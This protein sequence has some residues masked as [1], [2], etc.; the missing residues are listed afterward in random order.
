[1][2]T[3]L[4]DLN[5]SGR[6]DLM[7]KQLELEAEMLNRGKRRY[8]KKQQQS[9]DSGNES[10]TTH[11]KSLLKRSFD[12][13]IT[14]MI[15]EFGFERKGPKLRAHKL[16]MGMDA[17]AVAVI[18]IKR[19][20]D[21]ISIT[22]KRTSAC[23]KLGG[24]LEDEAY[25]KAYEDHN[26]ALFDIVNK[27][28][29]KRTSH[30][31]YRRNKQL[32][33]SKKDNFKWSSWTEQDKLHVGST[34]LKIF[35][36]ATG[37]CFEQKIRKKH[38]DVYYISPT[39]K[40]MDWIKDVHGLNEYLDPEFLPTII[41]P[42]R[43]KEGMS[44]GGGYY[45]KLRNPI[46]LVSG[47]NVSAHRN[48]LE[49]LSNADM[50][51]IIEGINKVQDTMYKINTSVLQVAD[52]IFDHDEFNVG[53]TIITSKCLDLPNKP[54]DI[55]T[56]LESRKKWKAQATITHA[57]NTKRRSKR[58]TTAKIIQIAK[59]FE[60]EEQIGFPCNLDFRSRMYY[61]PPYLNPQ[62]TD[63]AKSLL[64]FAEK[65]PIGESGFRWLC[66]HLANTYGGDKISL[67]DRV[68]WVTDHKKEILECSQNPHVNHFWQHAD[69]PWQFL[70][71]CM[72]FDKVN[73]HGLT[74]ESGLPIHIDGSCNGLQHFS[75]MF[76]DQEGGLAT[77][78]IPNKKPEDIYQ[79]VCNKV[80]VKLKESDD[81]LSDQWLDFGID[82][83]ATKRAVMVLPYGGTRYSCIDFVDEYVESRIDKGDVPPFINRSRANMFLA[84]MIYDSIGDTVSKASEAMSWLQSIARLI[85]QLNMPVYWL[86]PLGFPVKQA[87]YSQKDTVVRTKM[88]GRIRIK[89]HTDKIDKRRQGTG[90]S[91]NFIH[92]MD[93]NA[94]WLTIHNASQQGITSFSMVHDSYGTLAADVNIISDA[95]KRAFIELYSVIDP[96]AELKEQLTEYLPDKHKHKITDLPDRGDL[97][98]YKIMDADYF[99]C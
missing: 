62:G 11:G 97:D 83:K 41:R 96:I 45:T 86:S 35:I 40:I 72:E 12:V 44:V 3:K 59:K 79:I 53:S 42:K 56:N 58:L 43:W 50:P 91:P 15:K 55:A 1:M 19:I 63:L 84:H 70:A 10:L 17:K 39:A 48:F 71:A 34:C 2:V 67:D 9:I 66:I 73:T 68:Q 47:H 32:Q 4:G 88:M 28:L 31:G 46:M 49:D 30:Y 22:R 77:N 29:N 16:L 92:N 61:I 23:I 87:Y 64:T 76:R 94:M 52:T 14:E 98:L 36:Q 75:A 81:P 90:I 20:I 21:S 27:D 99:F 65:K 13:Y 80:I 93:S 78:L 54:H 5:F 7:E 57:I 26:K 69:K 33:Q 60:T 8:D 38:R 74:Y 82:R 24:C 51:T 89:S 18:A 6:K 25:F 37:F 85:A 95:T